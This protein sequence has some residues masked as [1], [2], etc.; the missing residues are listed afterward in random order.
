MTVGH[1]NRSVKHKFIDL[2]QQNIYVPC[3]GTQ[4]YSAPVEQKLFVLKFCPVFNNRSKYSTRIGWSSVI[5]VYLLRT[6][7]FR[8]LTRRYFRDI[9]GLPL[10]NLFRLTKLETHI[11]SSSSRDIKFSLFLYCL[12][13]FAGLDFSEPRKWS[14]NFFTTFEAI[15][16][17]TPQ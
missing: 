3:H 16:L 10:S 15:K 4:K 6:I 13:A 1:N 9:P 7:P 8:I 14:G 11:T 2:I 5:Q 17:S 12:N